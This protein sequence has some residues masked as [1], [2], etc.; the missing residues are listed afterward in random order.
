[1]NFYELTKKEWVEISKK[2]KDGGVHMYKGKR[3]LFYKGEKLWKTDSRWYGAQLWEG[4]IERYGGPINYSEEERESWEVIIVLPG[5]EIIP[6][7]TFMYCT[8][9]EVIIMADTVTRVERFALSECHSLK[10]IRFSRNLEYI[11]DSAIRY[12]TSL[13]SV[14]IPDSC[15]EIHDWVLDGCEKL[16]IFNVPRDHIEL[17]IN[18]IA[19][20]ALIKHSPFQT[21]KNWDYFEQEKEVNEWI[22]TRHKKFPLHQ[23]C[24][25]ENPTF[26][27]NIPTKEQCLEKDDCGWTPLIYLMY[28][29][30]VEFDVIEQMMTIGG[31]DLPGIPNSKSSDEDLQEN[32]TVEKAYAKELPDITNSKSLDK[33]SALVPH[34]S[35]LLYDL[36]VELDNYRNLFEDDEKEWIPSEIKIFNKSEDDLGDS[37]KAATYNEAR[38]TLKDDVDKYIEDSAIAE[39]LNLINCNEQL[40]KTLAQSLRT[41]I[42]VRNEQGVS[43]AQELMAIF[44]KFD[45]L[46]ESIDEVFQNRYERFKQ[47]VFTS[48]SWYV[49]NI[50]SLETLEN[51]YYICVKAILLLALIY[52]ASDDNKPKEIVELKKCKIDLIRQHKTRVRMKEKAE[53]IIKARAWFL[54]VTEEEIIKHL[55]RSN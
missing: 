37:S 49:D 39:K 44:Q 4:G 43:F 2:Y 11:G 51:E 16:T 5:V 33:G 31:K 21:D 47:Q 19:K 30:T 32:E 24:C 50:H 54:G 52:L 38:S 34:E 15:G 25:S 45:N 10:F 17:G 48:R 3:T 55:M 7:Q 18:V 36:L 12:C 41:L 20:T 23:L 26:N 9:V 40:I 27:Q 13:T 8:K 6:N 22:K 35:L 53:R 28:N 46:K 14:F 29:Y 42:R 1:M